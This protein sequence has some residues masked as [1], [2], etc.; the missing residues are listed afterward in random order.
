METIQKID[1]TTANI[2]TTTTVTT[3]VTISQVQND[4][5]SYEQGIIANQEQITFLQSEKSKSEILLQQLLDAGLVA[6]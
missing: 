2:I 6:E 4:I 1:E 3:P 5:A